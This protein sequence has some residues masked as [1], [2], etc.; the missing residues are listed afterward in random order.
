[1]CVTPV[2]HIPATRT[3]DR[4]RHIISSPAKMPTYRSI[5]T[6]VIS[7]HGIFSL[8]EYPPPTVPNDPFSTLPTLCDQ[9][10]A[11]VSVYIPAY[12]SSQFWVR[13]SIAPPYPPKALYY[14]KLFLKGT[15]VISWGCG[16][17]DG[18]EGRTMFGLYDSGDCW[19]GET[20]IE[21]RVLCF[22]RGAK[23]GENVA[24][25][26]K[27]VMEIKIYRAKG[28]MRIKPQVDDF[29]ALI[30]GVENRKGPKPNAIGNVRQGP[31]IP[32]E[33]SR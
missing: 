23:P 24:V 10:R 27:D 33:F 3:D 12:P 15:C 20:G 14:F 19:M 26:S 11:L 13:Y 9:D 32:I 28:R 8:P 4:P 16:E 31:P 18:Y 22:G 30:G 25:D 7:Q 17:E 6:S 21:R 2:V 1:M 29:Q 5:T